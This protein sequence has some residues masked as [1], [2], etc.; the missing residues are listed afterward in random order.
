MGTG[1]Y[2]YVISDSPTARAGC[3][4]TPVPSDDV[5]IRGISL[6]PF[7]VRRWRV[8]VGQT[9]VGGACSL[10]SLRSALAQIVERPCSVA[11]T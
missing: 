3:G 8:R 6:G 10:G 9:R 4:F 7:S 11:N 5:N 2:V 1:G